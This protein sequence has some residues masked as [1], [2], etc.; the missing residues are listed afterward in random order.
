MPMYY[1]LV[2]SSSLAV[3][4]VVLVLLMGGYWLKR[5][6]RFRQHGITMLTAIILHLITVL[7]VMLPSFVLG[8]I[9]LI[10]ADASFAIAIIAFLHG[11]TGIIAGA[12]GVWIVTSWRLRASLQYCTPKRK[13]MRLTLILW[14]IG[15]LL[16]IL[17]YLNFYTTVLPLQ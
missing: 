12:F 14:L 5:M 1:Q 8:V 4:I 6:K 15:L 2:A 16:G 3:Q 7:A 10:F 13:L 9:P 11:I 17:L